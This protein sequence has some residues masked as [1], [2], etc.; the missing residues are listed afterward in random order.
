MIRFLFI[1]L[2]L[3]T[4]AVAQINNNILPAFTGNEGKVLVV[5]TNG[6]DVEW[7]TLTGGTN[8][9]TLP[10]A[11]TNGGTGGTNAES[12]RTNLG[13]TVIG[14]A[15]FT[16]TNTAAARVAVG[17][18]LLALTNTNAAD[19]R[20]AIDL[21]TAATNAASAFQ[22]ASSNLTNLAAN[23]AAGL[24]NFPALLLRT[25][26]SAAGLTNF[27]QGTIFPATNAAPTNTNAPATVDA[28]VD[29]TVGT[30]TYKIPLYQ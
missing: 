12:G 15:V 8:P 20:T 17:L 30:N 3:A 18:P 2:A 22:P 23:D 5:A 28:W 16:A 13:V 24:T 6:A 9:I 19:F 11:V 1:F 7:L 14:D 10:I 26:G 25:N 4:A 27:A 29:L 21:G